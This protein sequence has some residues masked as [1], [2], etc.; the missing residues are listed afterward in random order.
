MLPIGC[1]AD[2]WRKGE[3]KDSG[4]VPKTG[5][6]SSAKPHLPLQLSKATHQLEE[7]KVQ[8]KAVCLWVMMEWWWKK[9]TAASSSA[10]EKGPP[11]LGESMVTWCEG[12]AH[13]VGNTY[14]S[15]VS[16]GQTKLSML[17]FCLSPPCQLQDRS[18]R[19]QPN[20]KPHTGGGRLQFQYAVKQFCVSYTPVLFWETL[21]I[22][23][24]RDFKCTL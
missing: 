6:F 7:S 19:G 20:P 22:V 21:I 2:T 1:Y 12:H 5:G 11:W 10:K 14:V 8:R 24:W 15:I 13:Q 9:S 17:N 16:F 23:R 3:D 18:A 4:L